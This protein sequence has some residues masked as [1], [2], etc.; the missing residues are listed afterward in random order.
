MVFT[1]FSNFQTGGPEVSIALDNDGNATVVLFGN[2]CAPGTS[3]IEASLTVAPFYTAL[4]TLQVS[5]PDV[6]PAGV[7][8]YP[9]PEVEQGDVAGLL[10]SQVYAVVY[11]ETDPVYAEQLVELDSNELDS[12]CSLQWEWGVIGPSGVP[13]GEVSGIGPSPHS[14]AIAQLDDDGNAVFYFGGAGCAAGTWDVI[15]DVLAGTDPT[16]VTTFTVDPPAPTI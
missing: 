2:N 15:A 7:T 14:E 5:P 9:N 16:Y 6:S 13:D 11:V 8:A 12:S 10:P 1:G 4:T 3:V